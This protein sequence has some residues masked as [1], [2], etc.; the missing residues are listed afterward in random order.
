MILFFTGTGNSKYVAKRLGDK[1]NDEVIDLFEKIRNSDY[2]QISSER[3]LI[4]VSPTYAWQI[5]HI[6]KKWIKKTEFTGCKDVYFVMTCGGEIGNAGKYCEKLCREKGFSFK[7]IKEIVM[8]ENYI[9][10]F[11]APDKGKALMIIE[12]AEP[13]IDK[14]ADI[15]SKGGFIKEN[16]NAIDKI[17]S[18]VVNLAFY[19][20]CVKDSDFKVED[21]C[22]GC[23]L[24]AKL[25]PLGNI[26]MRGGKPYW[27]G[28]C[29][30]CMACIC[31]CP[32]E[33]IEYGKAS[34]G[35]PR[36]TCPK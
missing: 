34:V 15:I 25:C 21:S 11:G 28:N 19:P 36:Y 7:G 24:C 16:V 20:V 10:M 30:H 31:H 3:P 22:I 29:T 27:V 18:S 9:A 17:K 6:L 32:K 23:G 8:P 14:A 5:P 2:S 4:F 12:K 35:Q 1:L 26:E 33:A 13:E